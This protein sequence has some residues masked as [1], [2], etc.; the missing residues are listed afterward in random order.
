MPVLIDTSKK[1]AIAQ[2]I[3]EKVQAGATEKRVFR[4]LHLKSA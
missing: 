3:K 1:G 2:F 4:N